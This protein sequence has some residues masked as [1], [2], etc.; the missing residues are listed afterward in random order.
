[1]AQGGYLPHAAVTDLDL[2][3]GNIDMNTGMPNLAGPYD[4]NNP[5][6]T[7]DPD[8]LLATTYGRGS[9]AINWRPWSSP[10]RSR[11]TPSSGTAPDGTP[12]VTDHHAHVQRPQLDHGLRQRHPDHDQGRERP[13]PHQVDI[14]GGFDLSQASGD[15]RRGQLDRRLRQLQ[16]HGKR[17]VD[18]GHAFATNGL[19]KIQIYATD[20]AGAVGNDVTLTFTL[21][22]KGF[23]PIPPTTA[24]DDC[25]PGATAFGGRGGRYA[26]C[27]LYQVQHAGLRRRDRYQ[28]RERRTV[29][30]CRRGTN[31]E[32]GYN[33]H[34]RL[35]HRGIHPEAPQHGGRYLH[36]SAR[37]VNAKGSLDSP[38]VTF[39]I[40]T[41]VRPR[42]RPCL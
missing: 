12:L 15:Q 4:P 32:V 13:R 36:C 20:D 27:D 37:A 22:A 21:N 6:A 5:T 23:P 10:A 28:Y 30:G 19:K 40:K 42:H 31:Y 3:L 35:H 39:T 14:I 8:V 7:P 16:D 34:D 17:P 9:F 25:H 26:A 38:P 41:Q 1:M 11:S 18:T 29:A 24:A 33:N 2:S